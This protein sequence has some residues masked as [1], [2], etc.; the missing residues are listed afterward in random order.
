MK[1][2]L[3]YDDGSKNEINRDSNGSWYS[4][5]DEIGCSPKRV[6]A[7]VGDFIEFSYYRRKFATFQDEADLGELK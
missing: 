3:E 4:T 7:L 1:I 2:I 5:G 6:M